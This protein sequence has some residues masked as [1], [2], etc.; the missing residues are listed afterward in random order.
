[1]WRTFDSRI[2][3]GIFSQDTKVPQQW[4]FP[5]LSSVIVLKNYKELRKYCSSIWFFYFT[6]FYF[7]LLKHQCFFYKDLQV[8]TL[9]YPNNEP[10]FTY[11][12][13]VARYTYYCDFFTF[14][15]WAAQWPSQR[16]KYGD[17]TTSNINFTN[18]N[19]SRS[20]ESNNLLK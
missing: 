19:Y 4:S 1:M 3:S 13:E 9:A 5:N 10:V 15:S 6:L 17:F 12:W 8:A 16:Q 2:S 7:T 20:C 11:Y 18:S 14:F